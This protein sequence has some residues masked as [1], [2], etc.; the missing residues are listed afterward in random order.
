M[1]IERLRDLN[2]PIIFIDEEKTYHTDKRYIY[3]QL[4]SCAW[5]FECTTI[6]R[7]GNSEATYEFSINAIEFATNINSFSCH[8]EKCR[9]H[10]EPS[11]SAWCTGCHGDP[12]DKDFDFFDAY[13]KIYGEVIKFIDV[14]Y[15]NP[16][17]FDIKETERKPLSIE[18]Y[19][20]DSQFLASQ[21]NDRDRK[22]ENLNRQLLLLQ[23]ES[24]QYLGFS[25]E[26]SYK[27]YINLHNK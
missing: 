12:N 3:P 5:R 9:K 26:D 20:K 10:L 2:P 7:E 6:D 19:R 8:G 25:S 17:I 18:L 21:L 15:N 4:D 24:Y 11:T 13:E 16:H 22:I 14:A 1:N 23:G 27:E